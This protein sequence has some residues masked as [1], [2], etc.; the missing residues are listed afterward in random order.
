MTILRP[1]QIKKTSRR[2]TMNHSMLRP[3]RATDLGSD[4]LV[5]NT[6]TTGRSRRER[7]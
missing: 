6:P 1:N 4:I 5:A 3:K 2:S 7:S